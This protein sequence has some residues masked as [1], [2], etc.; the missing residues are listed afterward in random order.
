MFEEYLLKTY[1]LSKT[2][3]EYEREVQMYVRKGEKSVREK[4]ACE[5]NLK[6]EKHNAHEKDAQTPHD[7]GDHKKNAHKKDSHKKSKSKKDIVITIDDEK[8]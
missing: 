1:K 7:T 2:V 5:K 4:R 3:N 6:R 8:V